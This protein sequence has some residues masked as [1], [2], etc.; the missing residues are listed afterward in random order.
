MFAKLADNHGGWDQ[1]GDS[2]VLALRVTENGDVVGVAWRNPN[3]PG[4]Y[5]IVEVDLDTIPIHF[6]TLTGIPMP[7]IVLA[8]RPDFI[9][10]VRAKM[11]LTDLDEMPAPKK[12]KLWGRLEAGALLEAQM[13]NPGVGR[14]ANVY[15]CL[16]SMGLLPAWSPA[17]EDMVDTCMQKQYGPAFVQINEWLEYG[18]KLIKAHGKIDKFLTGSLEIPGVHAPKGRLPKRVVKHMQQYEGYLSGLRRHVVKQANLYTDELTKTSMAVR[19]R[20]LI[21]TISDPGFF[22]TEERPV[23]ALGRQMVKDADD[24]FEAASR[25]FP[26]YRDENDPTNKLNRSL[27]NRQVVRDAVEMLLAFDKKDRAIATVAAYRYCTQAE[28]VY[29]KSDRILY[30]SAGHDELSVMHIFIGALI[31]MGVASPDAIMRAGFAEDFQDM[32]NA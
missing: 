12:G 24:G 15:M 18:Y 19:Q 28:D 1:D 26:K 13:I 14:V 22:S 17:M 11:T 8:D 10:E 20:N 30:A 31:R 7:S 4:E 23:A 9:D 5:A 29:G 16:S 21:P 25:L 2:V 27:A 3:S 32:L 6:N